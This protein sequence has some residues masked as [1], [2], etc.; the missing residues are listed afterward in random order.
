MVSHS[1]VSVGKTNGHTNAQ[2][3]RGRKSAKVRKGLPKIAV[4]QTPKSITHETGGT[5]IVPTMKLKA[6]DLVD[7]AGNPIMSQ[8]DDKDGKKG[9]APDVFHMPAPQAPQSNGKDGENLVSDPELLELLHQLSETIDTANTVLEAASPE[10][11][12]QANVIADAV[13]AQGGGEQVQQPIPAPAPEPPHPEEDL[14]LAAAAM[15]ARTGQGTSKPKARFGFGL[16]I[17]AALSGLILT[18]GAAWIVYTNPWLLNGNTAKTSEAVTVATPIDSTKD[19]SSLT[20]PETPKA[21]TQT[22]QKPVS[23]AVVASLAPPSAEPVPM[24]SA[25]VDEKNARS[26]EISGPV[27][28]RAG[29]NVALNM[30]LSPGQGAPETSVMV[31]GVPGESKLSH[32]KDLGS[33]NW[34]LNESQLG[35]LKMQTGSTVQPGEHVIE[36]IVVKSDGSVPETR[37]VTVMIDGPGEAKSAAQSSAVPAA[38][39]NTTNVTRQT[40]AQQPAA[41]E[42]KAPLP[43]LSPAEVETLLT[44]GTN[45]LEEGDVAGARL[46]LEY[47]AQRGSKEA[48]VKLAQSYDPDHLLK[49][50]VHGVQPNAE[51]SAHWYSRAQATQ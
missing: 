28:T 13:A 21:T 45:L 16:F 43:A 18:A 46:L 32:G 17:N 14:P 12:A 34:L 6:I 27:H 37:K 31:Q 47:A 23:G 30:A 41:V 42:K 48:M 19:Q 35:D 38:V 22:T 20:K 11:G 9:E 49:L 44:R 51:L 50:A 24:E 26:F 15:A 1:E 29:E 36:F 4:K 2:K 7:D 5:D 39:A 33:G 3:Q 25:A 8:N 10:A 40:E